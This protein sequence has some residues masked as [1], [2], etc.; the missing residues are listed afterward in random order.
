M[1]LRYNLF[2]IRIRAEEEIHLPLYKGSTFRGAFGVAFKRVVCA[3]RR[4]DCGDC[5]LNSRCVYAYV[6]ESKPEENLHVFGRVASIPR[7][8]VIEPPLDETR[9]YQTGE[10][11]EFN[12]LLIGRAIEYLPYFVYAFDEFG[13]QGI[14]RGR[15]RF[16]LERINAGK[17]ERSVTIYSGKEGKLNHT[18]PELIDLEAPIK[19]VLECEGISGEESRITLRFETPARIKYQRRLTK[20]MP[21]HVLMRQVLRRLFLLWYFHSKA[22]D[23]VTDVGDY[24]KRIIKL[25]EPVSIARKALYW[26]DWERYSNRQGSR[27]RLGGFLGDITYSGYLE[28]F[29]PFLRACEILHVGKGTTFGLGKYRII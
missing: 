19:R 2:R 22:E 3:L 10:P 4:A 26:H 1:R 8:Y 20:D 12:L 25:A 28:I 24:H 11:I 14:G 17:G 6:F 15:G 27:M 13:K 21:F 16:T 9:S 7:P 23:E 5:L 29:I 18:E